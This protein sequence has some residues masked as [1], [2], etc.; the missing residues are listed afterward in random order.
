MNAKLKTFAEYK[1]EAHTWITLAGGEYYPDILHDACTLYEPVL[2]MFGKILR[3]S[4]SS[5]RV[6]Q[7]IGQVPEGWMRIQLSRVFRK[8]VSPETPVEM[9]KRKNQIQEICERFGKNFRAINQVQRAFDSRPIPDEALCALLWEYKD[10]G[11]KG[12]DLTS[13][14]FEVFRKNFPDFIIAGPEGAGRDIPLGEIFTNYPNPRRPVDFIIQHQ[15]KTVAIG[16]ARYDSD[17]GGSQEDDRVGGYINCAKEI[18]RYADK[19]SLKTKIIFL[20]DGPGLLLGSMW[21]DYAAI[22]SIRKN[23]VVVTTLRMVNERITKQWL[24]S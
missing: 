9:L 17:R 20:N 16:L 15:A 2:V 21:D 1:T 23:R 8:Y 14:F 18:L 3:S 11:K 12:Y 7:E 19:H 10:R 4:E 5:I 13:R 24:L 6:L 22:E